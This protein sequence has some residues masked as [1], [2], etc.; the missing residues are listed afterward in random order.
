MG[1]EVKIEKVKEE[2]GL[3]ICTADNDAPAVGSKA[4]EQCGD[5]CAAEESKSRSVAS[6]LFKLLA[7]KKELKFYSNPHKCDGAF[8]SL[9]VS[10][11][12]VYGEPTPAG[13][14]PEEQDKPYK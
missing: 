11:G 7:T 13:S 12:V 6:K 8:T 10:S 4:V 9:T 14:V 3:V 5:S 2:F 1:R